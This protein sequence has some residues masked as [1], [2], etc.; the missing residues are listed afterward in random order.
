MRIY[1]YIHNLRCKIQ[2]V[3]WLALVQWIVFLGLCGLSAYYIYTVLG[4]FFAEETSFK[5]YEEPIVEVPAI[6]FCFSSPGDGKY[7]ADKKIYRYDIDF[8]IT[9]L[10][11]NRLVGGWQRLRVEKTL[12]K[13]KNVLDNNSF[14]A[15]FLL[16]AQSFT[17]LM[18]DLWQDINR[19]SS[20]S[21]CIDGMFP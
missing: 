1:T 7:S 11:L 4:K 19:I 14:Q 2:R 8:N 9:V 10:V 16:G 12:T 18:V 20:F 15:I 6:T 17:F 5:V 21:R 3:A 13:G